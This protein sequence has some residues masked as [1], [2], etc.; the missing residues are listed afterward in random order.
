M[1]RRIKHRNP[2]RDAELRRALF[3]G[4]MN[5]RLSVGEAVRL[6]Q[7]ISRLTQVEFAAHRGV[8]V[9]VLKEIIAGTANPTVETL[10]KI[11]VIFGMEVGFVAKRE[12]TAAKSG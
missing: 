4:V 3:E 5:N 7:K 9:R 10:N 1:D 11:A 8:S 2:E 12:Q 6:M